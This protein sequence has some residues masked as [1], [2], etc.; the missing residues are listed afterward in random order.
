MLIFFYL[1]FFFR[2]SCL[3]TVYC[4]LS[5]NC[6]RT[7]LFSCLRQIANSR[8]DR[9]AE[10]GHYSMAPDLI[11]IFFLKRTVFALIL[12]CNFP[13]DI[14]I[15]TLLVITT[16]HAFFLEIKHATFFLI[17]FLTNIQFYILLLFLSNMSIFNYFKIQ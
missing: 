14:W 17:F 2:V 10:D 3:W 4:M 12:F 16:C 7:F 8:C 13:M 11:C 6:V 9:S 1:S 15:W 5:T